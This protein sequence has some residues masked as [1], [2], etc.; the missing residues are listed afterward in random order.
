MEL[1]S[2]LM[3]IVKD[4]PDLAIWVIAIIFAY[5]TFIVG[6]IYATIRYVMDKIHKVLIAKK[7]EVVEVDVR[8]KLDGFTITSC[9][10]GLIVQIKRI[11]GIA[12][13][14]SHYIHQRDIEWL[15]AAIDEKIERDKLE[16]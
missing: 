13:I 12:S 7:T 4:A 16:K 11:A 5:K 3:D 8:G 9:L 1:I 10:D 2:E 15:K 6:S 14:D